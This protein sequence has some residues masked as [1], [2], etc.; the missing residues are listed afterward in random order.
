VEVDHVEMVCAG[1]DGG[2]NGRH[3]DFFLTLL[4]IYSSNKR[5]AWC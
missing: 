3:G 2:G 1:D 5:V 4:A